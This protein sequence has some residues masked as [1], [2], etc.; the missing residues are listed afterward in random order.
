M[1]YRSLQI[2]MPRPSRGSRLFLILASFRL[3]CL[4]GAEW[5]KRECRVER[6]EISMEK[7]MAVEGWAV[8]GLRMHVNLLHYLRRSCSIDF[9][10][11][12]WRKKT[13]NFS[14]HLSTDTKLVP[15]EKR[16]MTSCSWHRFSDK[17]FNCF[18]S[19]CLR[20]KYLSDYDRI[21]EMTIEIFRD[22]KLWF[23]F[24]HFPPSSVTEA[25]L[26][27][28][29][30]WTFNFKLKSRVSKLTFASMYQ[31][32]SRHECDF[33]SAFLNFLFSFH[34]RQFS[35]LARILKKCLE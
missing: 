16:G 35:F 29:T 6:E 7:F 4:A 24:N 12:S 10:Q 15:G 2:I 20:L 19:F 17:S 14:L 21:K 33:Q 11:F 5:C 3:H 26:E 23:I 30:N 28:C 34:C 31:R 22:A 18:S 25:A 13:R 9:S 8:S 27:G 32:G 1:S